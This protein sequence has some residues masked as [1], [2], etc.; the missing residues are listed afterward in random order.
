MMVKRK[1]PPFRETASEIAYKQCFLDFTL[2]LINTNIGVIVS[3]LLLTACAA[4]ASVAPT[5]ATEAS[6]SESAA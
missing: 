1:K 2:I 3:F 4:P 5:R 6:S